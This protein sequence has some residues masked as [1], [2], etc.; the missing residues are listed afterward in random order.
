M[1]PLFVGRTKSVKALEIASDGSKQI[2]LVAQKS[3]NKDEPDAGDLYEVGTVA[4]VLQMLKL[5]DGTVKVLVEGVQR[6]KVSGYTETAECFAAHAELIPDS[7]ADVE[8]QALMRTVFAQFDQYVKLN[9]KIP[10]RDTY[11][12]CDHR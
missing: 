7:E 5:P 12:S 1:I 10:P 9:K 3:A 6:A 2:L 11:F 8:V 4:T